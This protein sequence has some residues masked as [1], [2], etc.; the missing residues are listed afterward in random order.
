MGRD[1]SSLF[2]DF[3]KAAGWEGRLVVRP[4]KPADRLH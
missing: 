3:R 1:H 2:K 4:A